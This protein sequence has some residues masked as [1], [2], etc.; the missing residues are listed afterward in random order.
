MR[1]FFND[2]ES[3]INEPRKQWMGKHWKGYILT[4]C[5]V[6]ALTYG[7]LVIY[8][9]RDQIKEKFKSKFI[10]DQEIES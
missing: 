4:M 10:K 6:S 9:N 5:G 1:E 2:Y 8:E 3:M 7:A